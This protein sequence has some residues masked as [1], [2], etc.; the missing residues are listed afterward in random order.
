M[1]RRGEP[2][3]LVLVV[4]S[5]LALSAGWAR[6]Q[7]TTDYAYD[8]LGRLVRVTHEDG[9]IID[10]A[11]DLAGNRLI[12]RVTPTG[13][14]PNSPP[15]A[16][17]NPSVPD[18]AVDVTVSPTL[19][20]TG[21]D[22]DAGD[23]VVYA[24][25][26][27]PPGEMTLRYAGLDASSS[28]P[29]LKSYSG[30][31][32]QVIGRD[33][34]G[35]ETPGPI[36]S[37]TTGNAPP[38]ADFEAVPTFGW[39]P[40]TVYFFDRS[41]APDDAVV[42][43]E[44]DFESDGTVDSTEREPTHVYEE[45]GIYSVALRVTDSYGAE[46]TR[47]RVEL[48]SVSADTD[49]DGLLD[50]ADNCPEFFNPNQGDRDADGIGDACD[51]D[52]DGDGLPNEADVCPLDDDPA[53][54]DADGDGF[55]DACTVDVC[56]T[57]AAELQAALDA[58]PLNGKN[59]V[60]RLV[61]G[62]YL[63]TGGSDFG[64]QGYNSEPYAIVLRGGYDSG[65]S[66]RVADPAQ[67]AIDGVG[68]A[69]VL[70]LDSYESSPFA[71]LRLEGL[72][73]RGGWRSQGQAGV[74]LV[75]YSGTTEVVE[76]IVTGNRTEADGGGLW[77]WVGRGAFVADRV[78]VEDN[79]A[80]TRAG[81]HV[82]IYYEGDAVI[83]NSVFARNSSSAYIGGLEIS[84]GSGVARVINNTIVGNTASPDWGFAGGLMVE[85]RD[86]AATAEIHNNVVW[87]NAAKDGADLRVSNYAG[88]IW[89]LGHNDL[90]DAE[91]VGTAPLAYG[92][93]SADPRLVDMVSGDYHLAPDSP[94][95]DAADASA[96]S[97][98]AV[99]FEGDARLLG[100]A[101]DI[102]V[103]EFFAPGTTFA[104]SGQVLEGG[105]GLAGVRVELTGDRVAARTT[106]ASGAYR[107][108]WLP[109]GSFVV[110]PVDAYYGF[111][112]EARAVTL[113]DG[114]V[115]G[116]DFESSLVDTD[117]DG[118]PDRND[119][120]PLVEN[121]DQLDGDG[122]GFGDA[123]DVPG[124]I[125]GLVTSAETALPVP[126]ALVNTGWW[127][128]QAGATG[129]YTVA[130]LPNGSYDVWAVAEGYLQGWYPSRVEV[131]PGTDTPGIDFALVPD[132]DGDGIGDA[133]DNCPGIANYD[134]ADLDE[135]GLGDL[136]DLDLDDDGVGNDADTCP[137]DPN[138]DQADSDGDGYGDA[139]TVVHCVATAAEL[140]AVLDGAGYDGVNNVVRIV[141]G[142]YTF[143]ENGS[144]T[145]YAS[146]GEPYGI[147]LLGGFAPGCTNR[148][149]DPSNTL[150]DG[151]GL[152]GVISI[153]S[154][155]D[156]AHAVSLLEGITV[157]NG[158][159]YGDAGLS[160]NVAGGRLTIARSIFEDNVADVDGGGLGATT[161]GGAI[162]IERSVFR[163]NTSTWGSGGGIRLMVFGGE[164]LLRDNLTEGNT[165][166]NG[167]G[168]SAACYGGRL[169]IVHDTVTGNA[170]EPSYGVGGGFYVAV[171]AEAADVELR[172]T[173]AWGN[174]AGYGADLY[175]GNS[176]GATLLV[177][178]SD[179]GGLHTDGAAPLLVAN[180]SA[181][182]I[183]VDAGSGDYHLSE[184]SPCL[185]AADAAAPG[186]PATDFEGDARILGFA[187]DIGAD[188][189]HATTPAWAIGGRI[190]HEGAGV[191]GVTVELTGTVARTRVTDPT[192]AYLFPWLPAGSYVV[193]PVQSH[194][195]FVPSQR[196]VALD[197]ADVLDQDF[198]ADWADSDGDGVRDGVDNC[199]T[200][201]NADQANSDGDALGDA[202]DCGWW[203]PNDPP[204]PVDDSLRVSR[205]ASGEAEVSW[206]VEFFPQFFGTYRG[207]RTAGSGF[208]YNHACLERTPGWTTSFVDPQ[209]APAGGMHYYLVS[210][211][212]CAESSLGSDSA[213][214][215][216]PN[217]SPCP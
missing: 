68:L 126:G 92:N 113:V 71:R 184:A 205:Y 90:G 86:A 138:A 52:A 101:P 194:T 96:P 58:A 8:A 82:E 198:E 176:A 24:L 83:T 102:G 91:F 192:G 51:P 140:Q 210:Q 177:A 44:W 130:D 181:D 40:L 135:D 196:G 5:L 207:Q 214:G 59:D 147:A 106:D 155:S 175:L 34:R 199:E 157:R 134:Q 112:P 124:S 156:F 85:L 115:A 89:R 185:D 12:E 195:T 212:G 81:L 197:G 35:A 217:P 160:V 107:F 131:V 136:C 79:E 116:Q 203:D 43:W 48:V 146:L 69:G 47:Q 61:R 36:W 93:L 21:G 72:T 125:S 139:C 37:F 27:G 42:G 201:P 174:T 77:A 167:A 178:N 50:G 148:T 14:P 62:S 25:Y 122:D 23:A 74:A 105:I 99:D 7:E 45:A 200:V 183:F 152:G 103:D 6:S 76:T 84:V 149:L 193:T 94:C 111:L 165:A 121:S 100:A 2:A 143:T 173:I 117:L 120:C 108:P 67:T 110:T 215:T 123:C 78:R 109:P 97:L 142:T 39:G 204:G 57:S 151:E 216:R 1:R 75:T 9:T 186:M 206:T 88:A 20:W 169:R 137:R 179:F 31:Q 46:A 172:N 161:S 163:S 26:L 129:E 208:A 118:I 211:I 28:V 132:G 15:L 164:V 166:T 119:N 87:G 41:E 33:S 65:C 19:T 128:A 127:G 190:L 182:P 38:V 18:G 13:S 49:H 114:D 213:G 145:F 29:G 73:L 11:Y 63:A 189:Y 154:A 10:Y 209:A 104:I 150:L 159:G 56:V 170:S 158:I 16:P 4:V 54:A 32:W 187:P 168:V 60:L 22:P 64:F 171:G 66:S 162:T 188:E 3:I 53:Q 98:P 191:P 141:A 153:S 95:I 55:G 30:Y 144:R 70:A 180:L 202:C 133:S 80:S 17:A